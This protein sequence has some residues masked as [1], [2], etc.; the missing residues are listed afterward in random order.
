S[1]ARPTLQRRRSDT[2]AQ[3]LS[4]AESSCG[5]GMSEVSPYRLVND[6]TDTAYAVHVD[7]GELGVGEQD[8]DYDELH[9]GQAEGFFL[10]PNLATTSR[11]VTVTWHERP[12]RSDERR[13]ARLII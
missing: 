6:G 1:P 8:T 11:H 7:T 5:C 2:S 13:A 4:V 10:S 9:S 3:R 12:D